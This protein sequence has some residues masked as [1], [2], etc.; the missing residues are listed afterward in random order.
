M[1]PFFQRGT[2]SAFMFMK[3]YP[4]IVPLRVPYYVKSK[5]APIVG[6]QT[7][8]KRLMKEV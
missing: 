7:S 2:L 4:E 3:Q 5:S 6:W 8:K 1:V